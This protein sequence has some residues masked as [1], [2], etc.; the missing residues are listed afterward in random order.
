MKREET[1]CDRFLD[2]LLTGVKTQDD[3]TQMVKGLQKSLLER[4]MAGELNHHL[5]YEKHAVGEK[6]TE[7]RRNGSYDKTI[8]CPEHEV[9]IAVPRDRAGTFE[10]QIVKKNDRRFQGFDQKIISLY[11]RGMSVRDIQDELKESY[12][13]DVSA[14]LISSVTDE[15]LADVHE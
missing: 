4:A 12:D 7:N 11:S 5:G 9:T 8:Q 1:E 15:V 2:E 6:P 14:D 3:F 10:P 13:V